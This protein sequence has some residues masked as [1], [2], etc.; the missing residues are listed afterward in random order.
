MA[1]KEEIEY[2]KQE[3]STEEKFFESFFKLEKFYKK[4]KIKIISIIGLVII[5]VAGYGINDFLQKR[6]ILKVNVAYNEIL[7]NKNVEKN[8]DILRKDAPNLY[9]IILYKTTKAKIIDLNYLKELTQLQNAIKNNDL[10]TI[11][12]LILSNNLLL[13]DYAIYYKAILLTYK[14]EYKKAIAT[15][16]QI[17]QNSIVN[18]L[19]IPLLHYLVAKE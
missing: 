3:I 4:H 14:K 16:N 1:L 18:E 19:K 15:L 17:N 5:T 13:K 7:A 10:K 11:D 12:N 2:I 8:L 9:K 6:K